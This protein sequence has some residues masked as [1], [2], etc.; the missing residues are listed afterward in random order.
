VGR[1]RPSEPSKLTE[2]RSRRCVL[3]FEVDGAKA[4]ARP[5][6]SMYCG[7]YL[8]GHSGDYLIVGVWTSLY[9]F[10]VSQ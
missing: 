6:Q 2:R 3:V 10:C 4:A 9:R 1:C 5:P 8:C 7:V